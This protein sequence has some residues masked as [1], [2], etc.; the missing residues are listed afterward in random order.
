[1]MI[2]V[3]F[4]PLENWPRK[5]T[6]PG[7][8]KPRPFRTGFEDTLTLLR[9]E[10]HHLGAHSV[11]VQGTFRPDQIRM[12]GMPYASASPRSPHIA[13]S[14]ES[15]HGPLQFL[16]DDCRQWTDNLYA[17]AL[18]LERLRLADRY[19]VTR[20]GEQYKGWQQLPPPAAESFASAVA[21]AEWIAEQAGLQLSALASEE[22]FAQAYRN[23]AKKFHPDAGGD[24]V[25]F[26]QLQNAK[27]IIDDT[28]T[29]RSAANG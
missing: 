22:G 6:S 25:K 11:V 1:M 29:A 24:V 20:S 10:L 12:D 9:R 18:T 4:R 26:R 15:K 14:F 23:L 5:Q 8:R 19:G 27:A 2:S 28:R 16:C 3:E 13:I 17:I 7:D 21:A